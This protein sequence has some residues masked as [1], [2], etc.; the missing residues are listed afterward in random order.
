MSLSKDW[1]KMST[2]NDGVEADHLQWADPIKSSL[3]TTHIPGE[4]S[5]SSSLVLNQLTSAQ[6]C[7]L[8][9]DGSVNENRSS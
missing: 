3:S 4:V 6:A 9:V 7:V 2:V 8:T 5:D 1:Q